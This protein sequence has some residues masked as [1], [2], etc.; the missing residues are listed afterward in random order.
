MAL[1]KPLVLSNGE[2]ENAAV[3]D[4]VGLAQGGTGAVTAAAARTNLGLNIGS[5]VQAF[6]ADLNA[7]A[8]LATTGQLVRTAADTWATRTTTGTAGRVA[9]TNGDGVAGN[10]TVDLVTLADGGTGTFSKI[11]RDTYG[12]VS[13]TTGVVAS[14]ITALVDSSYVKTG[15]SS[16]LAAASIISYNAATSGFGANDLVPRSYVD[17]LVNADISDKIVV[18]VASTG[19][20]TLATMPAAVDG[21]TLV[22]GDFFLAK[23]QTAGAENGPYLF[24]GS[25]AA[26]TRLTSYN[27]SA[28][29]R[30][31]LFVFVSEGSTQDNNGYTLTTNAP[32][33]LGTT[34]LTFPQTS[35]AGQ[36]VGGQ[37]LTKTGNQLD[38]GTTD[39]TRIV[40]N[41]DSIDLG[42]PVITGGAGAGFTKVSVDIYGRVIATGAATPSDI[43]AQPLDGDLT[44]IA[45]LA[46]NGIAVKTAAN[47][48]A[49]RSLAAPTAG[50]TITNADGVAGNPT[51]ALANDLAAL[52]ALS[53]SGFAVRTGVDA[54]ASRT[55]AGTAGRIAVT[56]G[57]GISGNP[58]L[59][60]ASGI[61]TPGTYTSVTV[62]TFGRVTAGSSPSTAAENTTT[63]VTNTQGSAITI[64][65]VVYADGTGSKLARADAETTRKVVGLVAD[66]S[67]A[68][69]AGG[70]IATAGTLTATTTQ[71]DAVTGQTGGLTPNARY[72]LSEAVFGRFL[73]SPPTTGWSQ[74]IGLALS[75]TKLAINLDRSVKL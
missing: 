15:A 59:D 74:P 21:I 71:W 61:A 48:W 33:T 16:T 64:G 66:V 55:I 42:Q 9:V 7:I 53:V 3:G 38:V 63:A 69:N 31:G 10:P 11:T 35:G 45:A 4:F 57:D 54:W 36:V 30:P 44:A 28:K 43:G 2:I 26:A 70:N 5:D 18:R 17:T 8:A 23:D 49:I 29:M 41:A 6:D 60:L 32:I 39:A 40:V 52:E 22:T 50:I 25:G 62:D 51:L 27:T 67:I 13:G 1:I 75:T 56:N 58:G 68:N 65:Q 46:T 47:T 14:D 19:N 37:G 24:N 12:R 73:T 20:L 34:A 72:W